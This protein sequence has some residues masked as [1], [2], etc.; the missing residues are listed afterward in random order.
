MESID[1][2]S[3][4]DSYRNNQPGDSLEFSHARAVGASWVH[5]KTNRTTAMEVQ[6]KNKR[7]HRT[8]KGELGTIIP[9]I[10][11]IAPPD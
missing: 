4:L 8:Q 7:G 11:T 10:S 1:R 5:N 9:N 2:N 3:Q 6:N